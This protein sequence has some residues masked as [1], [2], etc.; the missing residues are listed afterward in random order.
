MPNCYERITNELSGYNNPDS[1]KNILSSWWNRLGQD[2]ES[3]K[4]L[5]T[6][7]CKGV[8]NDCGI[9]V[10]KTGSRGPDAS[11]ASGKAFLSRFRVPFYMVAQGK[12]PDISLYK[13]KTDSYKG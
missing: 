2:L 1:T 11:R 4:S 3:L 8:I 5:A 13:A 10:D 12:T 7:S 9:A 6:L